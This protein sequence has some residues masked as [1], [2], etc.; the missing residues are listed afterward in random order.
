M[1]VVSN[2]RRVYIPAHAEGRY[3]VFCTIVL[4][5]VVSL[6]T[7]GVSRVLGASFFKRLPF[8]NR[9]VSRHIKCTWNHTLIIS[10]YILS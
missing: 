3:Y 5:N 4:R 2:Y 6:E 8:V 10:I 1:G 7:G 9:G